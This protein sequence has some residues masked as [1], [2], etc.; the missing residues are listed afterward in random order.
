M[1]SFDGLDRMKALLAALGNPEA[2]F[3]VLH[4][5]G[6]NGKGST[7]VMIASMLEAAGYRVGLYTY[8]ILR[9]SA[10]GYSSGTEN[11]G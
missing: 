7:A 4:I 3:K 5:A 1:A 2:A 9:P 10:R 11:T 6:T 8:R